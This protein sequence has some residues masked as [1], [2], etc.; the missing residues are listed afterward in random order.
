MKRIRAIAVTVALLAMGMGTGCV[1]ESGGLFVLHNQQLSDSCELEASREGPA[2]SRGVLDIALNNRYFMY[3]TIENQLK[4]SD[5]VSIESSAGGG[6][7]SPADFRTE[8]NIVSLRGAEVSFQTPNNVSFAGQ[9]PQG[10]FIPV[11]GTITPEGIATTGLEVIN[12]NIG[13]VIRNSREFRDGTGEFDYTPGALVNL[14]VTVKFR[15]ITASG[16]EV[17][18]NEF[19]YPLDVCARCLLTYSPGTL[20]PDSDGDGLTCDLRQA[21]EDADIDV[22]TV[23]PPC[24]LGQDAPVDCTFC[25]TLRPDDADADALCDPPDTN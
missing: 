6:T 22:A 2:V 8:G 16:T 25:R 12:V 15:G 14:L 5:D 24:V 13:N 19:T 4:S 21:P 1:E 7:G 18:S 17:E 10:L 20:F 23:E 3:P 9:L 11:S